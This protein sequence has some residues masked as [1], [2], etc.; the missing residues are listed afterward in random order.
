MNLLLKLS[1]TELQY[2]VTIAAE[3][4]FGKA[5]TKCYV[6]QPTLSLAIKKLEDNLGVM[7][8]ERSKNKVII[9]EIGQQI[10]AKAKTVLNTVK[11]IQETAKIHA[12]P[13]ASKIKIGAIHTV[14]P[15]I[16]PSIMDKLNQTNSKLNII[17]EEDYTESLYVKLVNGV[18]D[19]III[20][21]PINYNNLELVKLYDEPLDIVIPKSHPLNDAKYIDPTQLDNYTLLL[22]NKGNC[23]RDQVLQ[24][25]PQCLAGDDTETSNHSIATTSLE[26]IKY[27][28]MRNLG[29]SI[30]PRSA[31]YFNKNN[32]YIVK[33][34]TKPVPQRTIAIMYRK[35]SP[36]TTAITEL[37]TI[38]K[39]IKLF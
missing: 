1:L 9:T 4:H 38:I 7:L 15:Y 35:H 19:A 30:I 27:M 8:F 17:I 14:G 36:F 34:F 2:L 23:F 22:L 18:L 33:K 13:F 20:A 6:S 16:F 29:I 3:L 5:A 32:N 31:V 28:V 11:D 37:V 24:I 10:I 39:S 25:C 26:T 12:N 21:L